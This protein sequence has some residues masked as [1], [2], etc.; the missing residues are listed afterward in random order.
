ME[1]EKQYVYI[2]LEEYKTL[3]M[4]YAQYLMMIEP[5]EKEK[6]LQKEKIGFK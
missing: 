1:N 4:V 3:L 6:E 5:V 2:P